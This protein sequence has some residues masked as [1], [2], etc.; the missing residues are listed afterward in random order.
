MAKIFSLIV[1]AAVWYM[2]ERTTDSMK[3][4]EEEM[5]V[6]GMPVW[7][8]MCASDRFFAAKNCT[9]LSEALA[10]EPAEA[11]HVWT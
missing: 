3:R 9:C 7:L 5:E 4:Y 8:N 2:L 1:P 6:W 10:V 11:L